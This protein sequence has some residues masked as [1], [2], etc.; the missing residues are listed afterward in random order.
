MQQGAGWSF[1]L[2]G[3][4]GIGTGYQSQ[5]SLR[6][7]ACSVVL[8]SSI[9]ICLPLLNYYPQTASKGN[10]HISINATQRFLYLYHVLTYCIALLMFSITHVYF[11]M[12]G[13]S[14]EVMGRPYEV[15]DG[16]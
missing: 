13:R 15:I 4:G 16:L 11:L 3:Q 9:D 5:R 6:L 1:P 12:M 10:Y 8:H 14:Y 2:R 7:Q